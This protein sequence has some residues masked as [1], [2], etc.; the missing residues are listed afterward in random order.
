MVSS[1]AGYHATHEVS[2]A[3]EAVVRQPRG[4][5]ALLVMGPPGAGKTY[6]AECL[7]LGLE[8]RLI[9]GQLHAWSDADELFYGVDPAAAVAGDAERVRQPGPAYP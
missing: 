8:A 2:R 3:V 7:A 6:L 4:I 1:L 9:I 5:R